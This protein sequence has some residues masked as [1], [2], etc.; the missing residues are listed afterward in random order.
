[1]S[2]NTEENLILESAFM[3]SLLMDL[4]P[5]THEFVKSDFFK[6][7][8]SV[9]PGIKQAFADGKIGVGN[10][11][12]ILMC[13][14]ALLVLPK[15]LISTKYQSDYDSIN[16][17]IHSIAE[18]G[19]SGI[20][21]TYNK[22]GEY[23]RHIRNAISHGKIKFDDTTPGNIKVT[24][25]DSDTMKPPKS[26]FSITLPVLHIARL[27]DKLLE[28]SEKYLDDVEKRETKKASDTE[29]TR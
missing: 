26:E 15:E 13:L 7:M 14:Y 6:T 5:A 19:I 27:L 25:E 23:L 17:F 8:P 1:M 12:T 22:K 28:V 4:I 29:I 21:D 11:G 24:F 16:T 9:T 10:Q 2:L 20:K 18:G 3:A